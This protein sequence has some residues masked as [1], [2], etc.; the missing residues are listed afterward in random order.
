MMRCK[1]YGWAPAYWK[2]IVLVLALLLGGCAQIIGGVKF[3]I[4][5]NAEFNEIVL[6]D[7]RQAKLLAEM[8]GDPIALKCWT[9]LEE[10]TVENAPST[11]S[12]VGKVTG[13]FSTYQQARN[14]RRNVIEVE[15]SDQFRLE[16]GPMLIESMGVL[17]RI[18][19][20]IAL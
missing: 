8:G 3:G 12:P 9:Y 11:E 13:V 7:V 5:T 4:Q 16:C 18:G 1:G 14:V 19:I 10:F 20:R 2:P 15:I 6:A 17:G